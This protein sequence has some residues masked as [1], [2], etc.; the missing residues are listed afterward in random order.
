M[1][2]ENIKRPNSDYTIRRISD[3]GLIKSNWGKD[4]HGHCLLI[5][6]LEGDHTELYQKNDTKVHGISIDL[7]TG[8][9]DCGQK[10]IFTLENSVDQDLFLSLC[11]TLLMS[12]LPVKESETAVSIALAN[13][14]RWKAFLAGKKRRLMSAEE[15]RGLFAELNFL[16]QLYNNFLDKASALSAWC[17]ADR[18]QQDF[19]F[20]DTAVEVKSLSGRE[21]NVIK[22]SSEDQ[23]ESLCSQLF[24]TA[25]RIAEAPDTS[26]GRSL[27]MLVND[28]FSDLGEE[29][30]IEA[31]DEK[32]VSYGYVEL[33]EY[34]ISKFV[35]LD[36]YSYR[37]CGDFPKLVRSELPEGL[38]NVSYE[39]ELEKLVTF[40]CPVSTIW[41]G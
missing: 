39:I 5:I 11:K 7:R 31:F 16:Q 8:A 37:V 28:I 38:R 23:L 9:P 34:E 15:V 18:V 20:L 24:L 17:G 13:I 26:K 10:L 14:K 29:K 3:T 41:E 40:K 25:Y 33:C 19:I 12:L 22:I 6:E 27:N 36:Q 32:L 35:V 2:W 30:L 21:R 1:P 4:V